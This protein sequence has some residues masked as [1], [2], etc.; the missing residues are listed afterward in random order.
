MSTPP[1]WIRGAPLGRLA[2]SPQ[3]VPHQRLRED[4]AAWKDQGAGSL[5]ACPDCRHEA[6]P[7]Q[8]NWRRSAGF[9]RCFIQINDIFPKEAIPQQ[10]L[11][12]KLNSHY[13]VSWHYFYQ[14]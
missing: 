10:Q 11:L 2:T 5:W 4:L 8:F 7:W 14:Y 13:G 12:D 9:G 6:S 1:F 3:P